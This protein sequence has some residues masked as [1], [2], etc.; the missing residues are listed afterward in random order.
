MRMKIKF[1]KNIRPLPLRGI[2]LLLLCGFSSCLKNNSYDT[3]FSSAGASVNLPLA[4]ANS[5]SLV[6]FSFT[7]GQPAYLPVY[8]NL[9][10][11]KT[12]GT[13]VTANFALDTAY[14]NSYDSTNSTDYQLMPDSDYSVVNGWARN[15]P[16]GKRLDSMYVNLNLDKIGSTINY[17]LPITIQNASV[18]IEQWNHLLMNILVRNKYDGHYDLKIKTVGWG[19]YGIADGPPSLDYGLLGMITNGA[20]GLVFENDQQPVFT[21]TSTATSFGAT[22]PLLTFDPVTNLLVS[23]VNLIPDDGRGRAFLIDSTVKTSRWDPVTKN[24]YAAYYMFQDGRP[25]QYIYDTLIYQGPRP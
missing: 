7:E 10:S 23:V 22:K 11:P 12:P 19:A 24:I 3:P 21:S 9:A 13:A 14:L 4:A 5:N 8:I 18:P 25:T 6:S 16:A 2:C 1:W 20:S 15:I 17:V